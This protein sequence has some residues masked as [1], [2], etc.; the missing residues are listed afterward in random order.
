MLATDFGK[1]QFG[2]AENAGERIIEFGAQY[3]TESFDSGI[4][5]RCCVRS[6]ARR[7]TRLTKAP[8]EQANRS[9]EAACFARDKVG[10]A[11]GDQ[12]SQFHPLAEAAN[13][14]H[15][16]GSCQRAARSRRVRNSSM[17]N[18]LVT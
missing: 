16:G 11:G 14:D 4:L 7:M 5:H 15:R 6:I 1:Q 12:G 2:I 9:R 18:G 3:F 13:D 10:E 17:R 8:L